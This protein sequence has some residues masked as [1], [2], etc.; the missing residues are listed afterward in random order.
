MI[1]IYTIE[2]VLKT[3]TK[4]LFETQ[5]LKEL[6][7]K[8]RELNIEGFSIPYFFESIHAGSNIRLREYLKLEKGGRLIISP[9][10]L[11]KVYAN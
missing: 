1:K 10:E 3:K 8:V 2:K 7:E 6:Q 11:K 5:S 9:N 4:V